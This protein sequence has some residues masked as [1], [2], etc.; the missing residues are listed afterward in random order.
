MNHLHLSN[1]LT[2]FILSICIH[3]QDLTYLFFIPFSGSYLLFEL[4]PTKFIKFHLPCFNWKYIHELFALLLN[5]TFNS[6]IRLKAG[7]NWVLWLT[8]GWIAY[9]VVCL[10][11]TSLCNICRCVVMNELIFLS[12]FCFIHFYDICNFTVKF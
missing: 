4:N 8:S 1:F 2:L 5:Y 10:C 9:S 6:S 11:D 12:T 3:V 7:T